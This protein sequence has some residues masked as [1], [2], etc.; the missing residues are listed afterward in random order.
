M[1]RPPRDDIT[2]QRVSVLTALS[3]VMG[4]GWITGAVVWGWLNTRIDNLE[5]GR[6]TPMAVTTKLE[7][8]RIDDEIDRIEAEIARLRSELEKLKDGERSGQGVLRQRDPGR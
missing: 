3:W 4:A 1:P 6:S 7:L 2:R 5:T 8:D